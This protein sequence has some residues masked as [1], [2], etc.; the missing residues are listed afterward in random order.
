MKLR[1][2]IKENIDSKDIEKLDKN[3]AY[4]IGKMVVKAR[5]FKGITQNELADL[6]KTKQP[7][8]ARVESGVTA[9]SLGF[10]EKIVQA[11]DLTLL[12]PRIK[13]LEF[14]GDFSIHLGL[15]EQNFSD[16][17]KIISPYYKD[18]TTLNLN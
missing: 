5:V 17:N 3:L 7:S 1:D 11:M 4:Q 18:I 6:V 16:E 9:P 13:E 14:E 8:I 15:G 2:Y 12:P 10:L